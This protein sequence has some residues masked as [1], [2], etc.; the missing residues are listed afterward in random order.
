MNE[1]VNNMPNLKDHSDAIKNSFSRRSSPT[2]INKQSGWTF[3]SL[4][5]T[6]GVII[7][8]AFIGI[9]LVPV[10]SANENIKNAMERSLDNVNLAQVSRS[11]IEKN[12][13]N[14]LYIDGSH[15]LLNYKTDLDLKR[16]NRL[17]TIK[18][19]YQRE[20]P[21]F[22]N[23]TLLVKFDNVIEKDLSEN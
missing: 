10:Y 4:I 12:M 14:Q 17:F 6:L 18:T 20:V 7:F 19:N 16:S 21:L 11:T 22:F 2:N 5:F 23:L 9:Q 15:R 3:W 8:F 13:N 1:T